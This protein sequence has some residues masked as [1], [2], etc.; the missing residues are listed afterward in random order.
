MSETWTEITTH[1]D[2]VDLDACYG[3][4]YADGLYR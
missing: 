2:L 1:G 3:P 4:S